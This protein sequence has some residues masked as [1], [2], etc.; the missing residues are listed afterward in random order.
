LSLLLLDIDNF[1]SYQD[2][3]KE[4]HIAGDRLLKHIASLLLN[5]LR[6]YDTIYRYGGEEIAIICPDS[7]LQE[8][9]TIA[10]RLRESI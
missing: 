9:I 4:G 7:T 8:G 10:E 1:K 6:D 5:R 3:H 2:R